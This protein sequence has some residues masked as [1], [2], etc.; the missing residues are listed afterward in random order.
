VEERSLTCTLIMG[1]IPSYLDGRG[2]LPIG[3]TVL[4]APK[5]SCLF[6]ADVSKGV[7]LG[8]PAKL[9]ARWG[10]VCQPGSVRLPSLPTSYSARVSVSRSSRGG[11]FLGVAA[12]YSLKPSFAL[13]IHPN[14]ESLTLPATFLNSLQIGERFDS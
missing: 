11:T 8:S 5:R 12:F 4:H 13:D 3:C 14:R 7:L 1:N 10:A 9:R 2:I 6:W